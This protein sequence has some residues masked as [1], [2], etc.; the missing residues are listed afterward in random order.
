MINDVVNDLGEITDPTLDDVTFEVARVV[1]DP[2]I[3]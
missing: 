1:T 3:V 2:V